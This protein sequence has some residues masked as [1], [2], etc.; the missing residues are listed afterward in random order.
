MKE[1][2][3]FTVGV[4]RSDEVCYTY[5][6]YAGGLDDVLHLMSADLVRVEERVA[7]QVGRQ[8]G[9]AGRKGALL[10]G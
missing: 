3:D 4:L 6:A 7:K 10:S 8:A 2:R 1:L 5:E 9:T